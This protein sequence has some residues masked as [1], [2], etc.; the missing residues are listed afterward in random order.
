MRCE[1]ENGNNDDNHDKSD[2]EYNEEMKVNDDGAKGKKRER[3]PIR[4][5]EITTREKGRGRRGKGGGGGRQR[6]G[7]EDKSN[8]RRKSQERCLSYLC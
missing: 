7:R 1:D 8:Y 6:P 4:N 3:D 5:R 2:K